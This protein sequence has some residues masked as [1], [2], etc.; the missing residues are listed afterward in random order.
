MTDK[1]RKFPREL[2]KA[3]LLVVLSV[4]L[5][6]V[7][8]EV[9]LRVCNFPPKQGPRFL[10]FSRPGMKDQHKDFGYYENRKIR[11]VSICKTREGFQVE[12]DTSYSTNNLGLVQKS[13]FDPAKKSLVFIG[14]SFTQGEGATPWFYKLEA[15][16]RDNTYQLVNLGL[17]GT[18]LVQWR[19]TLKWFAQKGAIKHIFLIFISDDWLRRRWYA[20]DDLSGTSFWFCTECPRNHGVCRNKNKL[21]IIYLEKDWDLPAIIKR[22]RE[23]PEDPG[24]PGFRG[25]WNNLYFRRLLKITLPSTRNRAKKQIIINQNLEAF[26]QIISRFGKENITVVHLPLRS[27]VIQ[28]RYNWVG[29]QAKALV[30]ARGVTYYDGLALCGL[31]KS[32]FHEQDYHPNAAGYAKI[33]ACIK[34]QVL[35]D[36]QHHLEPETQR[37]ADHG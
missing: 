31:T 25:F 12:Y 37:R 6:M 32:D 3:G 26:D 10:F 21:G 8:V 5:G 15:G 35:R 24:K 14:D 1:T 9:A 29:K 27:E 17:I 34:T 4:V 18:G 23:I 11:E 19:D 33:L 36:Y 30:L 28:G 16:W 2:L 20:H 13:N 22:A 7:L